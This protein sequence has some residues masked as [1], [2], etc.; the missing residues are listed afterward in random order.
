MADL[1]QAKG[2]CNKVDVGWNN[3][4]SEVV[5]VERVNTLKSSLDKVTRELLPV[6]EA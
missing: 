5:G 4:S 2:A 6:T 1:L 3:L